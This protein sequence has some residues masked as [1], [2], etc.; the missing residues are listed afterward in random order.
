MIHTIDGNS[1]AEGAVLRAMFEARKQVFVDLLKWDV[2]VLA[3]T[4]ELDSF[5]NADA[6]YIVVADRQG[7]HQASARLLKTTRAHILGDLFADLC[8]GEV[9][10]SEAILEI[11]RFCLDRNLRAHERRQARDELVTALA[12]HA[13]AAGIRRYTGVAEMAWFQQILSFGWRCTPLGLPRIR[14]GAMLAALAIDIDTETPA[15]LAAAG[16]WTLPASEEPAAPR[17]A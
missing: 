11:T 6:T 4:W 17:A 15:R 8:D 7:R 5:D 2:P 14:G 9:P 12:A 3:G 1:H 13:L 16:I 10:R